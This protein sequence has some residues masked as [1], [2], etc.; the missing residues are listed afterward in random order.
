MRDGGAG[1]DLVE[2]N[3]ATEAVQVDLVAGTATGE[4]ADSVTTLENVVGTR[5][6]DE[7]FGNAS[8][9]L[10]VGGDGV[11]EL[12]GLEGDDTL[13]PGERSDA[14]DGGPGPDLV[15]YSDATRPV[16]VDL[17]GG[18]SEGTGSDTVVAVE[19][20]LGS[21]YPDDLRGDSGANTLLGAGG[22]D[23]LNGREGDDVLDG[24][25]GVDVGEGGV[26]TDICAV[27]VRLTC[28]LG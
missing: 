12:V 27:E 9:N 22:D 8:A 13:R 16:L 3:N 2:Y 18:F 28:E 23:L 15:D 4:F 25:E 20:A 6:G 1:S 5:F 17:R 7:I 11:D 26:G 14:A 24:Q 19:N 21:G 10:L